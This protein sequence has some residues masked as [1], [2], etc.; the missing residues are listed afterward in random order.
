M[1]HVSPTSTEVNAPPPRPKRELFVADLGG[2]WHFT[3]PVMLEDEPTPEQAA[4]LLGIDPSLVLRITST[5]RRWTVVID[6]AKLRA[7]LRER[8]RERKAMRKQAERDRADFI[9]RQRQ[10]RP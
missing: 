4:R 8:D 7:V 5:A 1:K 2:T 3:Q 6:K 9:R 10:D